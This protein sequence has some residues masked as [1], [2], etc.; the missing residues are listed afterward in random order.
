M[1]RGCEAG[2]PWYEE[3]GGKEKKMK[4]KTRLQETKEFLIEH[5]L[6]I[7]DSRPAQEAIRFFVHKGNK[8]GLGGTTPS[9]RAT[10]LR[11]KMEE[12][13]GQLLMHKKPAER[14]ILLRVRYVLAKTEREIERQIFDRRSLGEGDIEKISP[15]K[16]YVEDIS[17][18]KLC[19]VPLDMLKL[20]DEM[21]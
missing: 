12:L 3:A 17:L 2:V 9:E 15:F 1:H 13:Q 4:G 21:L 14:Q 5:N 10:T 7:P 18:H 19:V 6:F 20:V 11:Q 8:Y 16:V